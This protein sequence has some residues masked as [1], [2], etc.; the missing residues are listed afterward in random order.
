MKN[1]IIFLKSKYWADWITPDITGFI[2]RR[3][4]VRHLPV[5]ILYWRYTRIA[6]LPREGVR[7]LHFSDLISGEFTRRQCLNDFFTISSE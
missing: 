6:G 5:K 1:Y 2:D 7:L 4:V 3:N